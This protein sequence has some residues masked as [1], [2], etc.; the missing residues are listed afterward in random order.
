[1]AVTA[2]DK[3]LP[4]YWIHRT[5]E[6]EGDPTEA[7]SAAAS[8]WFDVDASLAVS[9]EPWGRLRQLLGELREK[10]CGHMGPE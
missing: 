1:M 7:Q 8:S 6:F 5:M 4:C 2:T 3:R 10:V 9:A